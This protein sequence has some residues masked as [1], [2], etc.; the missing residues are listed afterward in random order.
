MLARGLVRR[1]SAFLSQAPIDKA[2]GKQA[3]DACS[4]RLADLY[5]C[6]CGMCFC[7]QAVWLQLL[8]RRGLCRSFRLV[9]RSAQIGF[10]YVDVFKVQERCAG[11][12]ELITDTDAEVWNN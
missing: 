5:R 12:A 6:L 1:A 4:K 3:E 8:Q 9:A 2:A 10:P 7:I 11:G